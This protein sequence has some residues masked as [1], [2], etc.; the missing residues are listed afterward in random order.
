[1]KQNQEIVHTPLR[2]TGNKPYGKH[3]VKT[4]FVQPKRDRRRNFKLPLMLDL[5]RGLP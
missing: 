1:M 2:H 4:F 5:Q 3:H